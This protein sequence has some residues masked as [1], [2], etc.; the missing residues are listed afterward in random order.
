MVASANSQWPD[1]PYSAWRET[2]DTLIL[3]TQIVGKVRIACTPLLNH[4]WNATFDVTS[5]GLLAPAMPYRGGTFDIGFDFAEHRLR[6]EASDGRAAAVAL[7]PMTVADFYA[8]IMQALHQLDIDVHIWTTP[9]EIEGAIPFEQDR[10]HN[11]YDRD[12]VERF[13]H[14]LVQVNRVFTEFRARFIG[15]VSPVHFFWGGLDLAVTRF[16]GRTA[17]PLQGE[18]PNVAKWVM[19]EAYS[20]EVSSCGFWPGNGGYGRAAF[21]V[22][23]YPEPAGYGD[24]VTLRFVVEDGFRRAP[25]RSYVDV[26]GLVARLVESQPQAADGYFDLSRLT[27]LASRRT[28]PRRSRNNRPTAVTA[29]A[30]SPCSRASLPSRMIGAGPLTTASVHSSHNFR[31]Q[32]PQ[33]GAPSTRAW[34]FAGALPLSASPKRW[35]PPVA[36]CHRRP[37]SIGSPDSINAD[38]EFP[39]GVAQSSG[40]VA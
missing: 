33:A 26:T 36:V 20:H 25:E 16:S 35:A 10:T 29:R 9:S 7:E 3:W 2:C 38:F 8:A 6:I 22:Y 24:P 19:N 11:H 39:S 13:W 34:P 31:S 40:T 37:S 27:L 32:L 1:L 28:S 18:T 5:R 12:Y 23:A 17:P 21:Y 15:K 30:P 14:A 4:W